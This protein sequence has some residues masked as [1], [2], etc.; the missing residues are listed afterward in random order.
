MGDLA[1]GADQLAQHGGALDNV[2]VVLDVDRGRHGVDQV[3]DVGRAADFVELPPP[4]QL[5]ANRHKIRRLAAFVQVENRL[6]DPAV[7]FLI[8]IL[9]LEK[10][11][12][13]D[14]RVGIDQG[15]AEHR[16]FRLGIGGN[17]AVTRGGGHRV[18]AAVHRIVSDLGVIK[19]KHGEDVFR[20]AV[21]LFN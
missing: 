4:L 16:L 20:L 12:D 11:G 9:R 17:E 2:A 7:L 1:G 10:R 6:V 3:H 5:V 8:K 13:L 18:K 19:A 15:R 21:R 14:D